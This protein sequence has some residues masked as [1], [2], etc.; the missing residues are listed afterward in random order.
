M[1]QL[2]LDVIKPDF[3]PM[4]STTGRPSNYQPEIFRSYIL[5]SHYKFGSIDDWVS[6]AAS[7]RF[8]C[9]LVGVSQNEYPGASTHRDFISRLWM[10][11]TVSHEKVFEKKPK[12]KHGKE[13]MPPKRPGI[14]FEMVEKALAGEVFDN[15]PERLFQAI[16]YM[17]GNLTNWN[18]CSML[19]NLTNWNLCS[20]L[21]N[22]TNWNLCSQK[23]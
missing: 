10:S 4:F 3:A 9:A 20:M 23:N 1:S 2:N 21:G 11:E 14:V 22:L 5:M 17:L 19:G 16:F 15:I 18:L 13:K 8:V 6:Y 12:K 7:S